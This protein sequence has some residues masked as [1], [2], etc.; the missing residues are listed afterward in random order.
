MNLKPT[1][2]RA[3]LAGHEFFIEERQPNGWAVCR[4]GHCLGT[5]SFQ[6]DWEPQPSSRTDDWKALHRFPSVE[7]AVKFV[8]EH[9]D[10]ICW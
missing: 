2:F 8:E 4:Q 3:I 7:D 9:V 10:R 1:V 5:D 6:F